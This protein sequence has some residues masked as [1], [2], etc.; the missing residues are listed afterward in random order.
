VT[1]AGAFSFEVTTSGYPV[2]TLTHSAL[3]DGL[4][5]ANDGRG[6]ATIWGTPLAAAQAVIKVWL[7]AANSLGTR[8]QVLIIRVQRSQ[9]LAQRGH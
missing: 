6:K 2:P 8:H 4:K 7:R 5:W 3:S 1:A 9:R